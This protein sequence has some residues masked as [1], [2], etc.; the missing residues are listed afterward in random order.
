MQVTRQTV[1][2]IFVII[3]VITD[4][5]ALESGVARQG[6]AESTE[7]LKELGLTGNE[8]KTYLALCALGPSVVSDIAEKAGVHRALTYATLARLAEKGLVSQMTKDKKKWFEAAPP[9]RLNVIMAE[10]EKRLGD[11]LSTLSEQLSKIYR[12]SARPTVEVYTGVEGLKTVLNDE[13]ETMKK[14]ELIYYYR[15]RPEIAEMAKVFTSWWLK[16]RVDKG[17]RS[18]AI[19]DT[20]PGSLERARTWLKAGLV[21][22]RVLPESMP[23]PITHHIYGDKVALL[24]AAPEELVGIIIKSASIANFFRKSF[25][26]QWKKLSPIQEYGGE[27]GEP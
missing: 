21:E 24:S 22:A 17:I 26:F 6:E 2:F 4:F 27:K 23:T 5:M 16:R 19:F 7:L 18:M 20:M 10:R 8:A 11:G 12:I 9:Q 14:G 25:E 3:V 15:V 13:L 1:I